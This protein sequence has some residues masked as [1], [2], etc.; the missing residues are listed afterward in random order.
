[1][2]YNLK[3]KSEFGK[4]NIETVIL[5][6]FIFNNYLNKSIQNLK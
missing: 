5:I 2:F 3:R 4:L 1:M 6:N